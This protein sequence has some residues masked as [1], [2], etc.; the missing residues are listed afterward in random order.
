M[1]AEPFDRARFETLLRGADPRLANAV[2]EFNCL[3]SRY[4][5]P[6]WFAA[7]PHGALL[8]RLRASPRV[9]GRLSRHLLAE[10]G[11][12]G[13]Y[14][15]EF[16]AGPARLALLDGATLAQL[17]LYAGLTA[18]AAYVRQTVERDKVAAL[19]RRMGEPAFLFALKRA[20]FLGGAAVPPVALQRASPDAFYRITLVAGLRCLA[21]GLSGREPALLRR[22]LLKFPQGWAASFVVGK[23]TPPPAACAGLFDRLI[24]ELAPQWAHLAA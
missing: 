4:A 6:S 24:L 14:C 9:A 7:L 13:Q 11:L 1:Q 5:H 19:K 10:W 18:T 20:P 8:L 22:L 12:A 21:S 17:V 23:T 2:L 15:F 3:P 16:G